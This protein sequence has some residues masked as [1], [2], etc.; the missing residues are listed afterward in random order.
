MPLPYVE[1]LAKE[2][3]MTVKEA[4][5]VWAKAKK[6]AGPDAS[7]AVITTIFKKMMGERTKKTAGTSTKKKKK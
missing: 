4:E 2:H 3:H 6:A 1:K 7:F 5:A